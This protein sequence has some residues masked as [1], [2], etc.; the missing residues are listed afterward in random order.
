[1]TD[2]YVFMSGGWLGGL[3]YVGVSWNSYDNNYPQSISP[4]PTRL[5]DSLRSQI[6][7]PMLMREVFGLR[8]SSAWNVLWM[9]K[10]KIFLTV[11]DAALEQ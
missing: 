10:I 6:C 11:S 2:V 9:W 3:T 8:I 5:S 1:M 7:S 4:S